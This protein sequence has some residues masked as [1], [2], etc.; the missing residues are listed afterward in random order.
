ML[1]RTWSIFVIS[2]ILVGLSLPVSLVK[3]QSAQPPIIVL[4][5]DMPV[6]PAMK[7]YLERGLQY[8]V[9]AKA[10]LVVVQL[11][12][13]GG[14]ITTMTEI[15]SDFRASPIPIVVYVTPSGGMAAS[16]GTIITL[17]G[18]L[19]AMA[20]NTIIGA[21]S[22]VGSQGQNID[23]TEETK[24]KE[25]L[26]ANVRTLAANRPP[27]AIQAAEDAIDNAKAYTVDEALGLGLVDIKASDLND[28]LTQL[29]GRTIKLQNVDLTLM[30]SG[31]PVVNVDPT[32]I[33]EGLILFTDP[34]I[35]F[36]L[37]SVGTL[38][39]LIELSNPG[40]W[41][42][43]FAGAVFLLLAFYGMGI[44][45]VNW[46]GLLFLVLAFILFVVDIKAPTHGLLTG[47]GTVS[48]VV[49]G[50]VLFNSVQIP[51]IPTISVPL[52]IATGIVIASGF[53]ALVTLALRAQ[54]HPV[55]MGRPLLIGQVGVVRS[56]L[57][58]QGEVQVAGE[59]WS[60]RPAEGEGPLLSGTRV[61][62][63]AMDG[64]KLR[65]RKKPNP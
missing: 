16:A 42:P 59:S 39:I 52:V 35:V 24:I 41:V 53:F 44:L 25:A 2:I 61:E 34:N 51:G 48:F 56:D 43:G 6:E 13:P 15:V 12:T 31:L 26:K 62:V 27:A 20:P 28:L 65:V 1:R 38:A 60:A 40:G 49:G 7:M 33:E 55:V 11:N 45:P 9:G 10:A 22:P 21:A 4:T 32:L 46:F 54:R 37:L 64:L 23:T 29:N 36:I 50:L 47:A 8:A 14:D 18:D 17:A 58:P 5:A 30:T 63:V 57:N 3:A 19:A